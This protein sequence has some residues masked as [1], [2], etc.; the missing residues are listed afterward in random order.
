MLIGNSGPALSRHPTEDLSRSH[1]SISQI[2]PTGSQVP[3]SLDEVLRELVLQLQSKQGF[4]PCKDD[5]RVFSRSFDWLRC[6]PGR[7]YHVKSWIQSLDDTPET[8]NLKSTAFTPQRIVRYLTG[9]KS[10]IIEPRNYSKE[11]VHQEITPDDLKF[12]RTFDFKLNGDFTFTLHEIVLRN[13]D[14]GS[15]QNKLLTSLNDCVRLSSL[16]E[17]SQLA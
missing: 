2:P 3:R 7:I 12:L 4:C 5:V 14:K 11:T 17:A 8:F 15:H 13:S 10:A 1:H 9:G 6:K 16:V